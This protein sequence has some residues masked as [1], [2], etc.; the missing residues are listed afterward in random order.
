MDTTRIRVTV[1]SVKSVKFAYAPTPQTREL[2]ET[3]RMMVNHAIHIALTENVRGRLNLRNRIYREFQ[4]QYGIVSCYPYSVAEVA[5]SIVKKHKRWQRKPY[6]SRLMMKIDSY[7][8][9]LNYGILSLP[10]TRGNRLLVPLKYGDWQRSFLMDTTLK[11]GSVTMTDFTIAIAF[12]KETAPIEPLRKVGIDLN[13]KSAVHSD[14]RRYDLSEV[15]RLHT[16]YGVRREEG[17]LQGASQ[18]SGAEAEVRRLSQGEG[19]RQA[20]PPPGGEANRPEGKGEPPGNRPRK[21][22]GNQVRP[23]EREWGRDGEE[24]QDRPLGLPAAPKL[25]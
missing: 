15:A 7:N 8:Y 25:H 9:S 1:K 20:D 12:S 22:E 4:A 21:I 19:A 17:L 23:Q 14:G 13:E 24:A 5:W 6:A 16:E 2:L 3:F 10:F 18:R 11:R